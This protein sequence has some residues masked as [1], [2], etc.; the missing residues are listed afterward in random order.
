MTPLFHYP[1][2]IHTL[3]LD[4]D[5]PSPLLSTHL[6]AD[7]PRRAYY[8]VEVIHLPGAGYVIRKRSG[9][10][11]ARPVVESWFRQG[12]AAAV[13]KYGQL[14]RRKVAKQGKAAGGRMYREVRG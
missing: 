7:S 2:D 4:L 13:E 1:N 10:D 9:A 5:L 8:Q 12:Y 6:V 3:P 14:V 11:G